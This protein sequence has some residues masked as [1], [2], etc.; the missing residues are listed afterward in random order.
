MQYNC[1]LMTE[2]ASPVL[3]TSS[4]NLVLTGSKWTADDQRYVLILHY[5]FLYPTAEAYASTIF[6]YRIEGHGPSSLPR[7]PGAGRGPLTPV[8]DETTTSGA[9]SLKRA[10]YVSRGLIDLRSSSIKSFV[11]RIEYGTFWFETNALDR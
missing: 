10:K 7:R 2:L 6:V 9:D 3:I 5:T 1:Y 4:V 11:V 8:D